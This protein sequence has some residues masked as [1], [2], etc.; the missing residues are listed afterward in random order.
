MMAEREARL[1]AI[2]LLE[3]K[4]RD[5]PD[6][7]R[8]DETHA[9]VEGQEWDPLA[10]FYVINSLIEAFAFLAKGNETHAVQVLEMC[11]QAVHVI[12]NDEG[13]SNV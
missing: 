2:A 8:W 10:M 12:T 1:T 13:Q 5:N 6:E 7:H 9:L 3:S 4:L 11:R